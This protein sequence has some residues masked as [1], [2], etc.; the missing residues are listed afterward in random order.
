MIDLSSTRT[1]AEL[2]AIRRENARLYKHRSRARR[3]NTYD[4]Q[5]ID[6]SDDR[7]MARPF[8]G[9]DGEGITTPDGTHVYTLLGDSLG[10]TVADP[11]GANT[12]ACLDFL[13]GLADHGIVCGFAFGYDIN[14]ML[15]DVPPDV[16]LRLQTTGRAFW[17]DPKWP[18]S[19]RYRIAWI[20]R[21]SFTVSR[22]YGKAKDASVT[23]WET[24][25]FFQ[26]SFSK[27]LE[28][29][30]IGTPEERAYIAG[31]KD[32][33]SDFVH[34]DPAE[35][36]R[37]N[38]LE[39]KLLVQLLTALRETL[40]GA[41]IRLA[42]WDGAGAVAGAMLR[43][44][45]VKQY[46][47]PVPDYAVD[48]VMRAYFGGRI[49]ALWLGDFAGPVHGYDLVSAYPSI[50]VDLPTLTGKWL[51]VKKYDPTIPYAVWRCEW[52]IDHDNPLTPFPVRFASARVCYP[53]AGKGWYHS[54]LVAVATRH[55][56]A[57]IRVTDGWRFVPD[58]D[59]KPF[60][61]I[62]D[63][64]DKRLQY[65]RAGDPRHVVLKLGLNSLYG[66]TAQSVGWAGKTPPNQ[67][68]M[69]AGMI[70]AGTQAMMLDAATKAPDSIIGFTTDGI[71]SRKPLALDTSGK[72]GTWEHTTLDRYFI[73]QPGVAVTWQASKRSLKTRG[74]K[75]TELDVDALIA[76]WHAQGTAFE[77]SVNV[78]RFQGLAYSLHV[79]KLD[80]WRH[81]VEQPRS[82]SCHPNHGTATVGKRI[83]ARGT[84][85]QQ[86][87][88]VMAPDADSLPYDARSLRV[89]DPEK[90]AREEADRDID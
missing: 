87:P 1:A 27:A 67:S 82:L 49:Q 33:R 50:L 10:R 84:V 34:V 80:S 51:R 62:R 54:S 11:D 53:Y 29:W 71:Y 25:G 45:N 86:W 5:R 21:K 39:C 48:A 78:T 52:N 6:G 16:L 14:M 37:Y 70:T 44:N 35:V 28:D 75:S 24:W 36:A 43:S 19:L 65:K 41:G 31:M 22:F 15:R 79:G 76:G 13:L 72:L 90:W 69:W 26:S 58:S 17:A 20:N 73:V 12:R 18:K 89:L 83:N 40:L 38:A 7:Y 42:R 47:Q 56:G 3:T 23:V 55:F 8:V 2:D 32:A 85:A 88:P 30:N 66:K 46:N 63:T 9:V 81:W 4:R 57:A 68:Y 77:M 59:V 64:F 60:A 61:W 74:F